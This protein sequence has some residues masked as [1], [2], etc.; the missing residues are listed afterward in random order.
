MQFQKR[1]KYLKIHGIKLN[2]LA[3]SIIICTKKQGG[4]I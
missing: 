2:I 4:I 3:N 1:S